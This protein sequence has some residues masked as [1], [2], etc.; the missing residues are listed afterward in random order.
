MWGV[1]KKQ[2]PDPDLSSTYTQHK[3]VER[4]GGMKKF[5]KKNGWVYEYSVNGTQEGS[6]KITKGVLK[7]TEQLASFSI[8]QQLALPFKKKNNSPMI[9]K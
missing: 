1:R 6:W 3:R 2:Y 9:S 5:E 8:P 7:I 4:D